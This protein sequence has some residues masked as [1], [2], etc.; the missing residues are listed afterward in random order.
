MCSRDPL[1]SREVLRVSSEAVWMSRTIGRGA[2]RTADKTFCQQQRVTFVSTTADK[3]FC[4]HRTELER[5]IV[6]AMFTVQDYSDRGQ[7][8]TE[9]GKIVTD[10]SSLIRTVLLEDLL[11]EY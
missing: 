4:Q 7:T 2:S 1:G 5:K 6:G 10:L 3:T 8:G 9:L 11:T